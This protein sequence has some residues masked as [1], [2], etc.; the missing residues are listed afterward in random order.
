M[1]YTLSFPGRLHLG[2]HGTGYS[3]DRSGKRQVQEVPLSQLIPKGW[4]VSKY[5]FKLLF[6]ND[7]S[8]SH[9]IV[10]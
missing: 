3:K 1:Q 4:C 6:A 2:L 7:S 8:F 9:L 10:L 5:N